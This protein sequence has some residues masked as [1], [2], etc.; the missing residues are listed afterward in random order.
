MKKFLA[1]LTL[2]LVVCLLCSAAMADVWSTTTRYANGLI[3]VTVTAD[4]K[5]IYTADHKHTWTFPATITVEADTSV[6]EMDV[7]GETFTID[8]YAPDIASSDETY[9]IDGVGH[10]D[11]QF[12]VWFTEPAASPFHKVLMSLSG[13]HIFPW[14]MEDE[15]GEEPWYLFETYDDFNNAKCGE[16]VKG[17]V[18]CLLCNET[19]EYEFIKDH[20]FAP[21]YTKEPTCVEDGI[22][23]MVCRHCGEKGQSGVIKAQGHKWE[24]GFEV[25]QCEKGNS[26]KA[27]DEDFIDY[28]K[29]TVCGVYTAADDSD[30]TKAPVLASDETKD[31]KTYKTLEELKASGDATP[32]HVYAS[33]ETD[34]IADAYNNPN[35]RWGVDA[36]YDSH[37][38]DAWVYFAPTCENAGYRVRW[39]LR[40]DADQ[41]Q[42]FEGMTASEIKALVGKEYKKEMST[43]GDRLAPAWQ[44]YVNG[45]PA[46]AVYCYDV[47]DADGKLLEKLPYWIDFKCTRCDGTAQGHY[48]GNK[49]FYGSESEVSITDGD[50]TDEVRSWIKVEDT[51]K[52]DSFM[53][54]ND[55]DKKLPDITVLHVYELNEWE[56]VGTNDENYDVE[57]D[58]EHRKKTYPLPHCDNDWIDY[59]RC[60]YDQNWKDEEEAHP[61][62]AVVVEPAIGHNWGPW[63]TLIEPDFQENVTG[64]YVRHCTNKGCT[65]ME[66]QHTTHKPDNEDEHVWVEI[67]ITP[68]TCT[69]EGASE[70]RCS[71]SWCSAKKDNSEKVL[72]ALGHDWNPAFEK[73][74]VEPTCTG[75]GSSQKYCSRCGLLE[76]VPVPALG[77]TWVEEEAVAPT[78]AEYGKEAG[79][80]C[81][82]CGA[83]EG[84]AAIPKTEDH[85]YGEYVVTKPAT[86][87]EPGI[88]VRKCDV[89]GK[90]DEAIV[91]AGGHVWVED[92]A[93]PATCK[94]PGKEAGKTCS[95]CGEK[96]GYAATPIDLTK[97]VWVVKNELEA[98]TCV[99]EG[100]ALMECS[101]CGA[102]ETRATEKVAHQYDDGV[103][104]K[105]P[106][107]FE[108]GEIT[109][110]C[111]VCGDTY[112]EPVEF[113]ATSDCAYKVDATFD[114]KM[115]KGTAEHDPWTKDAEGPVYARITFFLSDDTFIINIVE[116]KDG[117]IF[118]AYCDA[119]TEHVSVQIVAEADAYLPGTYTVYAAGPAKKI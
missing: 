69:E 70:L 88:K 91:E 104:T 97:H 26:L 63:T 28:F 25:P 101:V 77:H 60:S 32:Y 36:E 37:N 90:Y 58:P 67:V 42:S 116:V 20:E 96:E 56:F 57:K 14:D 47:T 64:W 38:W 106:T 3:S 1:F 62:H 117:G 76:I 72:P 114:G 99:A 100:E 81:S 11:T 48:A 19:A 102:L 82:V 12:E 2:A 74:I 13:E 16:K 115:V 94:E 50:L 52:L 39:C 73:V 112:T 118:A 109:Y 30:F 6:T 83:K 10:K 105:E 78:C 61:F 27:Y 92:E 111:A 34:E 18:V 5:D 89:C 68:A 8:H 51:E 44:L 110:T 54:D 22:V 59:Y 40:C 113:V 21:V 46:D 95:V 98:A 15:N 119:P 85:V 65:A 108:A 17:K 35:N 49:Y 103:V 9:T 71:N 41:K 75:E 53:D 107:P 7:N 55:G 31:L 45:E 23:E 24:Y 80:Y 87:V 79:K 84:Y 66:E 33:D 43:W 86:C 29:C 4:R 93:V